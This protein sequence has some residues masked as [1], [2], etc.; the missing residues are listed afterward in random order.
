MAQMDQELAPDRQALQRQLEL[1]NAI[2]EILL[3]IL[4]LEEEWRLD[5]RIA[6]AV[7]QQ[8]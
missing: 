8:R 1:G 2:E 6:F 7:R 4:E 3:T 5:D